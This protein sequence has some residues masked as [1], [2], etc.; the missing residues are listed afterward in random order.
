MRGPIAWDEDP[1]VNENVVVCSF[2]LQTSATQATLR[3]CTSGY[4][5]NFSDVNLQSYNKHVGDTFIFMTSAWP[6]TDIAV[7]IA[8]QKISKTVQQASFILAPTKCC[9]YSI[10]SKLGECNVLKSKLSNFMWSRIGTA[11]RINYLIFGLN[12]E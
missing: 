4:R 10:A 3:P 9:T 12:S 5:L 8:L 1:E 6:G 11:L 7:S 2:M